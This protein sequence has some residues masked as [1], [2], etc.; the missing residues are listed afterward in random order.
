MAISYNT[1]LDKRTVWGDRRVT[2]STAQP[3]SNYPLGGYSYAA[4]DFGMT[5]VTDIIP[6][7][8]PSG[9]AVNIIKDDAKIQFGGFSGN[10][11]IGPSPLPTNEYFN[12]S[13]NATPSN[14]IY[15]D[16]NEEG[17]ARLHYSTDVDQGS[18]LLGDNSFGNA[19][20]LKGFGFEIYT[21]TMLHDANPPV[22]LNATQ[23]FWRPTS[24]NRTEGI[25]VSNTDAGA[26]TY[27]TFVNS[28]ALDRVAIYHDDNAGTVVQDVPVYFNQNSP[29][30]FLADMPDL[31]SKFVSSA[32]GRA[33]RVIHTGSASLSPVVYIDDNGGVS[34][35]R[36]CFI[37]P[38]ATNS[39]LQT[40]TPLNGRTDR[41]IYTLTS[42]YFQYDADPE[43][44][45]QLQHNNASIPATIIYP[46][47]TGD[48]YRCLKIVY[49]AN[50]AIDGT[51]LY[52]NTGGIGALEYESGS[53]V[54]RALSEYNYGIN[55]SGSAVEGTFVEADDGTD[56]SSLDPLQLI[57]VGR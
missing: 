23:V 15:F 28:G 10:A 2:F 24:N 40:S 57:V 41:D 19:I 38:T 51:P 33:I 25:F 9:Y 34:S 35:S 32:S 48:Q 37:S 54:V 3:D 13:P 18:L 7:N 45:A 30:A 43:T 49:N 8:Y 29:V 31:I 44:T 47:R 22:N 14:R 4:R 21:T 17:F 27:F 6:L 5:Q 26:N 36:L 53:I 11:S 56:L 20:Q 1:E 55:A 52:L 39:T 12:V 46:Y 50:A 16:I 42:L